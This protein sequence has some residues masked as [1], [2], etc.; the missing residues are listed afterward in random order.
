MQN[1]RSSYFK[2]RLQ[3]KKKRRNWQK[4]ILGFSAIVVFCTVYA[5]ILPAITLE[6]T[7][8][9]ET[10]ESAYE[11]S[12]EVS[13]EAVSEQSTEGITSKVSEATEEDDASGS[14]EAN[15]PIPERQEDGFDLSADT[16]GKVKDVKL[17]YQDK[18]SSEW[19]EITDDTVLEDMRLRLSIEYKGVEIESLLNLYDRKLTYDLPDFLRNAS[20]E[21]KIMDGMTAVGDVKVEEGKVVLTFEESYLKEIEENGSTT[22]D[23]TFYAAGEADL[24]QWGADGKKTITIAGKDYVLNFGDD[25]VAKLGKV[26]VGKSCTSTELVETEDGYYL[27]Y[28]ITVTAGEDGGRNVSVVDQ[29]QSNQSALSYAEISSTSAVLDGTENGQKPYETIEEGKQHGSIGLREQN[30][31]CQMVWQIGD[32]SPK[33]SR[34][35]IYFVKLTD[36]KNLN[37]MGEIKNKAEVYT[38]AKDQYLKGYDEASFT[39]SASY[40]TR[41]DRKNLIQNA[42]GTYQLDYEIRFTLKQDGSNYPLKEFEIHDY[43]DH[44]ARPTDSRALAYIDYDEDSIKVYRKK[45]GETTE[46]LLDEQSYKIEWASNRKGF[47]VKELGLV[48]PGD[49]YYVRYQVLVKPEA[50]AAVNANNLKVNNRLIVSASNAKDKVEGG[51]EG[52]S[53]TSEIAYNAWDTKAFRAKTTADQLVKMTGEQYEL[54]ENGVKNDS[55]TTKEFTVPAGSYPYTVQVNTNGDWD[56]TQVEMTDQL[57]SEYMQ[58]VGY[59]KVEAYDAKSAG[60]SSSNLP[61]ET[62]WVKIDGRN[63]FSLRPSDLGWENQSYAYRFTYYAQPVNQ[64]LFSEI[65]VSNTFRLDGDVIRGGKGYGISGISSQTKVTISGNYSMNLKKTAWYYE[66]PVTG[67]G[68]W[69]KGKIYWVIEIGGTAVKKGMSV[70]DS[71]QQGKNLTDSFL[72]ADSLAGIYKGKLAEGQ[73]VTGYDTLEA[74]VT[75]A[76]MTD[77]TEKFTKS[78]TNQ[79]NFEGEECYSELTVTAKETIPLGADKLYLV[80]QSEPRTLPAKGRDSNTYKNAVSTSDNQTDWIDRD[81]AE[82]VICAGG[83]ILKELGQV[84][85]YDGQTVV[86]QQQGLDK[87]DDVSQIVTTGLKGAGVYASWAFKLNYAGELSGR[88]RV[89]E[90]IPE[91]MELAYIRVKWI[92]TKQKTIQAYEISDLSEEWKRQEITATTDNRTNVKTI[93]YWKDHQAIIELGNFIAGKERDQYSVDVQVVCRVTDRDVL[94]GG[95]TKTFS[96]EVILQTTDGRE[97]SSATSPASIAM[98]PLTKEASIRAERVTFTIKA[99]Q[100]GQTIPTAEESTKLR[101]IDKLSSTLILDTTTI[102]VV[103]SQ[104]GEPVEFTAF[105]EEDNTLELDLPCNVPM[106]ITYTAVVNAPPGQKVSFTN[107]AYW[108]GYT[109]SSGASAGKE[110]YS[111]SAGGTAS[112]GKNIRLKIIK[113][114]KNNLSQGLSGAEFEIVQCTLLDDGTIETK[115]DSPV[116]KGT[117]DVD[118]VLS[119]GINGSAAVNADLLYNTLYQVRETKAPEGYVREAQQSYIIVPRKE[120]NAKDYTEYVKRCIED[121]RVQVQYQSTYELTV[122]NHKGEITVEKYF[123]NAGGGE[124]NPVSGTYWF[125]LYENAEGTGAPIQKISITYRPMETEIQKEKFIN[126]DLEKKYYVFEL[127]DQENPV[128]EEHSIAVIEGMEYFTS[129]RTGKPNGSEQAGNEAANG[130][131]VKVFNQSRVKKLPSTGSRG[132]EFFLYAGGILLVLAGIKAIKQPNNQK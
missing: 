107:N 14:V 61:K 83:E 73:S 67:D 101:L 49:S 33:E 117:T 102:R 13:E 52:W 127:D 2:K 41:K 69:I 105:M 128:K 15:V 21:G 20:A 32:L 124:S 11:I 114:D 53:N 86:Q 65:Q 97:I 118:G 91:G 56:M 6:R 30:N 35:L 94:L 29:F 19:F 104:T 122:S 50:I 113:K 130:E 1:K 108:E 112:A 17:Y 34:T 95:E 58:Y 27:S 4:M 79:K 98:T 18:T 25:P 37:Q 48:Y 87:K 7:T 12:G 110:D 80:I 116:W 131:I 77:V 60:G 90:K 55:N 63:S 10:E 42:D 39:P 84:F 51:I 82:K 115:M 59:V 120:E 22:I 47:T 9:M 24:T 23:G 3:E 92:G 45:A 70:R 43:L 8:E 28:T 75:T 26:D 76:G 64:E 121:S 103:H 119:F 38:T 132:T 72:H 44:K 74:F 5:L 93:S 78:L 89:L 85:T 129:Y 62:K 36:Q 31:A 100:L 88:Y 16:T 66:Q 125:G 123:K 109:P 106:T 57:S 40:D 126:L 46:T 99:N 71:I 111:Y 96:N 81:T 68:T 54:T